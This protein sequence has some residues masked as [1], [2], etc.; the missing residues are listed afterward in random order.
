M[1]MLL[2]GLNG[3]DMLLAVG[4]AMT[5]AVLLADMFGSRVRLPR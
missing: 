4:V 3:L 2:H 5:S 1:P